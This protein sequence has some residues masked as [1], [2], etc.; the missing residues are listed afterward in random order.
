MKTHRKLRS[1]LANARGL[2]SAQE[3]VHHWW[4]Q[5]VSA[6]LMIPLSTWMIY[7][8]I[9]M[10]R[11]PDAR[12]VQSWLTDPL[13]ALPLAALIALMFYHARLGL[14]VVIEDYVHSQQWKITL[15]LLNIFFCAAGTAISVLAILKLHL[16]ATPA[17]L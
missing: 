13:A 3:G 2:G 8:L 17:L 10:M 6:F 12:Y 11:A 5:R 9:A 7:T 1:P 16:S 14:Q 15:L 4:G